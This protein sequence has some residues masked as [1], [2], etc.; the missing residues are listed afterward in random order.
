[1]R[2]ALVFDD[3]AAVINSGGAEKTRYIEDPRQ[4][5]EPNRAV[6]FKGIGKVLSMIRIR[7]L[8]VDIDRDGSFGHLRPF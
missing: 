1:M 7:A 3:P 5:V 2:V 4:P 8:V 6:A